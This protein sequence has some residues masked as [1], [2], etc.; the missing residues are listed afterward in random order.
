MLEPGQADL[1][2]TVQE[3]FTPEAVF[4]LARTKL[5][6]AAIEPLPESDGLPPHGDHRSPALYVPI[7]TRTAF[8]AAAV[9]IAL[10]SHPDAVSMIL[11][12]RARALRDHPG[13]VAFPGG[14]IE[15]SDADPAAAALREAW[16]EIGLQRD[17]VEPL[18]YLDPYLTGSGFL[19]RPLVA[20]VD[21]PV[22]LTLN[23]AE[24]EDAFEVPLSVLMD[25]GRHEIHTREAD[26]VSRRF[27]AM[28][29]GER[30]VWGAT[31]GIVRNFYERLYL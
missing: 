26:G 23:T 16:E 22:A 24:V 15:A 29:H 13:Q 18:G 5:S 21:P 9:L 12:T 25:A 4:G 31:A 14:K 8:R 19:I 6:L 20:K 3:G 30:L 27:Y 28:R 10:V 1:A 2:A 17:C 7:K 11:T